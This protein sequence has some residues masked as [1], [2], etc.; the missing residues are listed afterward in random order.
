MGSSVDIPYSDHE[1]A[2][3]SPLR[4]VGEGQLHKELLSGVHFK[5]F[6]NHG[7]HS[8]PGKKKTPAIFFYLNQGN[9]TVL[10]TLHSTGETKKKIG[11]VRKF[12][13]CS[14]YLG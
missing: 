14:N 11:Y 6:C 10:E 1:E 12:F 2:L 13:E 7:I 4:T 8:F 9:K 5:Y 3:E